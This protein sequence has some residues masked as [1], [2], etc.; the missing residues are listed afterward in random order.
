[1]IRKIAVLVFGVAALALCVSG[2]F[3]EEKDE[4]TLTGKITC[5]KCD[6]GVEKACATVIVV[7]EKDKDVTYYF[8]KEGSKKHHKEVCTASK[9][10]T[11]KGTVKK[12]GEKLV[13]TVKEVTFK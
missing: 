13:V 10:G 11:V 1:M 6:L 8:D 12:D 9:E 2:S 4:K 7:K 5:A 3:A